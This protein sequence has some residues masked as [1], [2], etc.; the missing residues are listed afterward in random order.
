MTHSRLRALS[1]KNSQLRSYTH[2]EIRMLEKQSAGKA[3]V[4][5]SKDADTASLR[6]G[7]LVLERAGAMQLEI[8]CDTIKSGAN[9]SNITQSPNEITIDFGS[10]DHMVGTCTVSGYSVP[11]Q[12]FNWYKSGGTVQDSGWFFGDA[13]HTDNL[14]VN[15]IGVD[16]A[17]YVGGQ[18]QAVSFAATGDPGITIKGRYDSYTPS[19][20]IRAHGGVNYYDPDNSYVAGA[21]PALIDGEYGLA[22]SYPAAG[23]TSFIGLWAEQ[24]T[25][26]SEKYNTPIVGFFKADNAIKTRKPLWAYNDIAL[27]TMYGHDTLEHLRINRQY[28]EFKYTTATA[29]QNIGRISVQSSNSI[30]TMLQDGS[31]IRWT[32]GSG[33]STSS[34][35]MEYLT[36]D[37]QVHIRR[38]TNLHNNNLLNAVISSSSDE[39]LKDNIFPCKKDCLSVI[40]DLNLIEFD[41]KD[42]SGHE[43]IGFSAQQAGSVSPDLRGE[44]ADGYSTVHEGRLIRYLVGAVQQLQ[45]E[46]EEL[47]NGT[48]F[49]D[50]ERK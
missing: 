49:S 4:S 13:I 19:D 9:G 47:K 15:R 6:D 21:R 37:D 10:I 17:A 48:K 44:D 11:F 35:I 24:N 46:L 7:A 18:V 2:N 34:V 8:D 12:V 1:K 40:K 25:D 39:R 28:I 30:D 23:D 43:D 22:L 33:G 36:S 45:K 50:N 14:L 38:D 20:Q 31:K 27:T 16:T 5:A 29:A 41:W 42:G 3:Q 32:I 26:S